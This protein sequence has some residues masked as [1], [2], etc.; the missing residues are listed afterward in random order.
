ME[1]KRRTISVVV[2]VIAEARRFRVGSWGHVSIQSGGGEQLLEGKKGRR[3]YLKV[4]SF[5]SVLAGLSRTPM[6]GTTVEALSLS[7]EAHAS[8]RR[9]FRYIAM[10]VTGAEQ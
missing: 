2:A 5:P 9:L 4:S 7:K 3:D 8:L 1:Q 10:M 6:R